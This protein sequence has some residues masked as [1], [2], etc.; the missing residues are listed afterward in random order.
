LIERIL[1]FSL[2]LNLTSNASDEIRTIEMHVLA[3]DITVIDKLVYRGS[4]NTRY[5]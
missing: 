3:S 2:W 4:V 5:N 1:Y